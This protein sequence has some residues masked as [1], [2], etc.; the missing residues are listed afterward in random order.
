MALSADEDG[1]DDDDDF[2]A[3]AAIMS[4]T[5]KSFSRR[6]GD[7][8]LF[9]PVDGDGDFSPLLPKK[10]LPLRRGVR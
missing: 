7:V 4:Y 8:I 10:N 2:P 9:V 3:L 1:T 6:P 5:P